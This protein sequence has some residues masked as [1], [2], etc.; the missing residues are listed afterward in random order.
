MPRALALALLVVALGATCGCRQV[1]CAGDTAV[2]SA[3]KAWRG[4][5][6]A[7]SSDRSG[8]CARYA[9][10]VYSDPCGGDNGIGRG[11][12]GAFRIP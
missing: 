7:L 5:K 6:G 1:R 3:G 11:G 8:D 2:A 4:V 9:E 12:T 10:P